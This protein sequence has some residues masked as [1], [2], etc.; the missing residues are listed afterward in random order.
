VTA[1]RITRADNPLPR[2]LAPGVFWLGQC[3][4]Q[5]W[6]GGVLHNYNSVYLVRGERHSMLIE[7]GHP[8]DLPA[9]EA[10]LESLLAAGGAPLRYLFPTHQE[11]PHSSGIGRI[12]HR[13][14]E[15]EVCGDVRDYHLFFPEHADRFRPLGAGESLDLGGRRI[16]IVE[17]VV[18][19]LPSTRWAFDDAERVLFPG[20]GFAYAHYH[21]AGMC[22]KLAEEA[23]ELA[24]AEMTGL[25]AELA[26]YWT[27][28]TD[29]EPYTERLEQMLERLRVRLIAPT[30]GLPIAD[31]AL[32]VPAV[33]DGLR[34]G[35]SNHG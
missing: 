32:T 1:R 6:R 9:I 16:T 14:P 3:M 31:P 18:L 28:F 33:L 7:A 23:G 8:Q 5:P 27:R 10:Q 4:E 15:V 25:F 13:H 26:L 21:E 11:T 20:D 22:G 12:L 24:L 2:E 30:H 29:M 19:D 34:T 17:A 35:G